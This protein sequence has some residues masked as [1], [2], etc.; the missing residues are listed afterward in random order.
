MVGEGKRPLRQEQESAQP[1]VT[2]VAPNVLRMQLPI[3]MPGLG[4]VNAYALIDDRGAAIVDPGMPGPQSWSALEDRMRQ[5]G[6]KLPNVHTVVVTHSHPDHFGGAG[7]LAEASGAEVVTHSAFRSWWTPHDHAGDDEPAVVHDVDP[8]DLPPPRAPGS[9]GTPWGQPTPWGGRNF[10]PPMTRRLMYRMLGRSRRGAMWAPPNPSNR[11]KNGDVV[12]LAGREW[13]AVH[14]PG[15][16]LDHLCLHDPESGVLLSGDHVL[17]TITPHISGM[18]AGRDPLA[19]FFESLDRVAALEGVTQVL[20]AHGHPFHDLAARTEAI[21]Q[22]HRE[23]LDKLRDAS[24]DLGAATVEDYSH[25][26]FRKERWGSM[27]ES[28]TYAHLEHLRIAGD[29]ERTERN[30]TLFYEIEKRT[31]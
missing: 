24:A 6:L 7:R 4:H 13:F 30:G 9:G 19:L 26:L 27:A 17:P 8:E 2:E 12:K 22:H 15:H 10:K 14:T 21:K 28:E 1:E 20:P 25:V 11:L 23:R 16:T 18:G 29:A 3:S 5:A 31:S